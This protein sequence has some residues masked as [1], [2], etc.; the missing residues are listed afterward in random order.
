MSDNVTFRDGNQQTFTLRTKDLGG[1]VHAYYTMVVTAIPV[2]IAGNQSLSLGTGS[3]TTLTV[4]AGA[5]HALGTIDSSQTGSARYWED[6]SSPSATT[7][8]EIP[9]GSGAELTNLAN[10]KLRGSIAAVPFQVGY[11]KYI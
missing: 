7:G 8:F 4:P 2:V 9:A 10:I 3:D 5:T 1:G 11:R 6:G